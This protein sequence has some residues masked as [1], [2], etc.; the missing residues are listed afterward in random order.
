M[1]LIDCLQNSS[2][3]IDNDTLYP[4]DSY[5]R[6]MSPLTAAVYICMDSFLRPPSLGSPSFRPR[7]TTLLLYR[8]TFPAWRPFTHTASL[9]LPP[10]SLSLRPECIRLTAVSP[11]VPP[12][13]RNAAQ[14]TFHLL[15]LTAAMRVLGLFVA[16]EPS[17]NRFGTF[18]ASII[19]LAARTRR[20][21]IST[22]THTYQD[23]QRN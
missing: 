6:Y 8:Q 22:H 21:P 17:D 10:P 2:T 23:W 4:K 3:W 20:R 12:V 1:Y 5:Q 11:K 15:C 13:S 9:S 18:F 19:Q 16:N 7:Q 14:P